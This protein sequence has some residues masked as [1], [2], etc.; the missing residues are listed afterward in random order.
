MDI[1]GLNLPPH[2]HREYPKVMYAGGDLKGETRTVRHLGEE[3]EAVAAGFQASAP[4]PVGDEEAFVASQENAPLAAFDHDGDGR[5]G[6]SPRGGNRK[7][8]KK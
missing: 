3:E 6:G 1:E 7:K 4:S 5:P 8:A 2:E